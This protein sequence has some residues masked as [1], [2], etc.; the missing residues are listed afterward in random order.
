MIVSSLGQH[1]K[2]GAVNLMDSVRVVLV[3]LSDLLS[4]FL[5]QPP[6][7]VVRVLQDLHRRTSI[8]CFHHEPIQQ[9]SRSGLTAHEP[10]D[11]VLNFQPF[12]GRQLPLL[13]R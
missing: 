5:E 6:I 3:D 7:E 8:H 1:P 9:P 4:S 11:L 12:D 13:F 2:L 10:G